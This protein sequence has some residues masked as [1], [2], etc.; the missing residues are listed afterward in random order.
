MPHIRSWGWRKGGLAELSFLKT[1]IMGSLAITC[2]VVLGT[3]FSKFTTMILVNI[4]QVMIVV[5]FSI[6]TKALKNTIIIFAVS[7]FVT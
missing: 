1:I 6:V 5:Q 7:E 4:L 2:G 3:L